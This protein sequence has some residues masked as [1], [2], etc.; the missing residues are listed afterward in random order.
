MKIII[1]SYIKEKVKIELWQCS[2]KILSIDLS[3]GED[4]VTDIDLSE[5]GNTEILAAVST[6]EPE[7]AGNFLDYFLWGLYYLLDGDI[8]SPMGGESSLIGTRISGE[9]WE[10]TAL[11]LSSIGSSQSKYYTVTAECK[12][13]LEKSYYLR[14]GKEELENKV[15]EW[16][17]RVF[18]AWLIVAFVFICGMLYGIIRA[19]PVMSIFCGVVI[20]LFVILLRVR[21]RDADKQVERLYEKTIDEI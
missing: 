9:F 4:Y 6:E 14:V 16:K 21:F 1:R 8:G 19:I 17:K 12:E 10:D 7:K 20:L 13:N 3:E 15:K 11:E 2:Q 5:Y 18:S